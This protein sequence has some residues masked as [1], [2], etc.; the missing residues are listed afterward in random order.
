MGFCARA[1]K[2]NQPNV[3]AI[4]G[5]DGR[6]QADGVVVR[7]FWIRRRTPQPHA[8]IKTAD[9]CVDVARLAWAGSIE[10][11]SVVVPIQCAGLNSRM[12]SNFVPGDRE[13]TSVLLV[14][15]DVELCQM[16][17]EFLGQHGFRV[18]T[19]HDGRS[20]L[21]AALKTGWD[22]VILDVML[23][24][25]DG[26]EV[27]RQMRRRTTVPVI[28]LTARA[29]A[30]DRVAG[31]EEGADDYL[32]KPFSASELLARIRAVWRRTHQLGGTASPRRVVESGGLR[33]NV[34]SREVGC[35]DAVIAL[36]ESEAVILEALMRARGRTV[37]RDELAALL[38]QREATPY[39][40]SVDVHISHLRK[41]LE[42]CGRPGIRSARGIG[43]VLPTG[44]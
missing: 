1:E 27:L 9:L 6:P 18:S 31:L 38:Y 21:G 8:C 11:G 32:V 24:V 15:D 12:T 5:G 43:Y 30:R 2:R 3:H 13:P 41:K 42:P 40:R 20:G 28:M 16:M 29:D 7:S 34:D 35:G 17:T 36:S 22:L 10:I 23:P 37:S 14:D 26:F 19:V 4:V 33:L 39:E 44:T 25:I